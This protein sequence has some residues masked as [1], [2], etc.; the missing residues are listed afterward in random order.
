MD[1]NN[2]PRPNLWGPIVL[3]GITALFLAIAVGKLLR[4]VLKEAPCSR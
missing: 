2:P 4:E 1:R 3:W